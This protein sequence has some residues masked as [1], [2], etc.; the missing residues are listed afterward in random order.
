MVK[1][2]KRSLSGADV[3]DEAEDALEKDIANMSPASN[4]VAA[5]LDGGVAAVDWSSKTPKSNRVPSGS[6][7]TISGSGYAVMVYNEDAT[8]DDL[9][10]DVFADGDRLVQNTP[11][12]GTSYGFSHLSLFP[13]RFETELKVEI[14]NTGGDEAGVSYVLD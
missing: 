12:V 5:N 11:Y 4:S 9:E 8:G 6:A 13:A 10:V 7:T 2:W 1:Q 14:A 3:Q